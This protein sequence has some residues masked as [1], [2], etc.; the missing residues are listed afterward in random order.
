MFSLCLHM[1]GLCNK[2]YVCFLNSEVDDWPDADVCRLYVHVELLEDAHGPTLS[3]ITT[4]A[5]AL[6]GLSPCYN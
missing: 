6:G 3:R 2:I 1:C 4:R 5:S